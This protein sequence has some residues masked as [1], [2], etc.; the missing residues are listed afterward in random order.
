MRNAAA[1]SVGGLRIAPM[2][3]ADSM[4]PPTS[5]V[6]PARRSNGQPTD[7]RVT[8][9]ATPLPDTLP[10][11]RPAR[12]MVR[13]GALAE[14][15]RPMRRQRPVDE[16][17]TGARL[18]EHG[19]I[20]AEQHDVGSRDIE[21]HAEY[22]LERHVER[23][24]DAIRSVSAM[25]QRPETDGCQRRPE[26]AVGEKQRG[27]RRQNPTDRPSRRFEHQENGE[28]TQHEIDDERCCRAIHELFEVDE[29]P[30]ER[31]DCGAGKQPVDG[32]DT[33]DARPSGRK[34]EEHENERD[35][36]EADAIDLWLDDADDP[37][38]GV[39]RE[40]Y[41]ESGD[42]AADGSIEAANRGVLGGQV[43]S[44]HSFQTP[45]SL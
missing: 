26:K 43:G 28:P 16:E 22:S 45:R 8:V 18:F 34:T 31:D 30:G 21:R 40:A 41:G 24:D 19:A 15:D 42:E 13:A 32:R 5:G 17:A 27:R 25:R 3:A 4:A 9:V 39:E 11:R 44:D 29:G 36:Q 6:Y 10:S 35:Q 2:P 1:P 37:V 23:A 20:D 12:A 7:P 38:E 14:P 33:G